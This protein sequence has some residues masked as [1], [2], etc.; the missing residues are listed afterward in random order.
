MS[1]EFEP[2]VGPEAV[3]LLAPLRELTSLKLV[4]APDW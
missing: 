2:D 3:A 1:V 4:G